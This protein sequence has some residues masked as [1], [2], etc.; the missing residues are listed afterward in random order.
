MWNFITR[1]ACMTSTQAGIMDNKLSARADSG[2]FP[3]G[4]CQQRPLR[5]TYRFACLSGN[6]STHAAPILYSRD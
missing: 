6:Q 3:P 5:A 2:G 4:D 1:P